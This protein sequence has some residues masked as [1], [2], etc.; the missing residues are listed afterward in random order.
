MTWFRVLRARLFA[1][2][3]KERVEREMEEE[4]RFH[5]AKRVEENIRRGMPSSDAIREAQRQFGN[6]NR[7][8]DKWRDVV[9][10][11]ALEAFSQDVRFAVRMLGKDRTFTAVALLA[12]TLSIGANTALFTLTD[13]VL[14]QPLPYAVPE[15]I[16]AIWSSG[17]R[18]PG[19]RYNLCYP[20]FL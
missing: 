8:K 4:L 19:A 6:L 11:G 12:L 3:H 5:I 18:N 13:S 9:G 16:M 15:R 1:L 7:V 10:A 20:D 17:T 14:L 2:T